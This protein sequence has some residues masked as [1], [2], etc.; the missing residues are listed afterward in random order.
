M[1]GT[2]A[3]RRCRPAGDAQPGPHPPAPALRRRRSAC[4]PVRDASDKRRRAQPELLWTPHQGEAPSGERLSFTPPPRTGLGGFRQWQRTRTCS[5]GPKGLEG[6]HRPAHIPAGHHRSVSR[7]RDEPELLPH[8][9]DHGISS[10]EQ[11]WRTSKQ[12]REDALAGPGRE[13]PWPKAC[14]GI[15][16]PTS[17]WPISACSLERPGP[18]Q[19]PC[20]GP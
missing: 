4:C 9:R 11:A 12:W 1:V 7:W 19:G 3:C 6:L 5:T 14:S 13:G 16:G 17:G 18:G 8:P 2:S 15:W 10:H 20:C